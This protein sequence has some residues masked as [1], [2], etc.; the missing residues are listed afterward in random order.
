[1]DARSLFIGFIAMLAALSAQSVN[2][3]AARA[4]Y[5]SQVID[6]AANPAPSGMMGMV[7]GYLDDFGPVYRT[8]GV[9]TTDGT[10]PLNEKTM[11]A[12]GSDTKLFAA[13]LLAIANE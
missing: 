2:P 12:I 1:M 4:A 3:T 10:V 6:Q 13:T 11:F 7:V 5:V 9:A 8:Y